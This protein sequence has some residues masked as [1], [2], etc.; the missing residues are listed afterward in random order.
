MSK[1]I[2]RQ[3]FLK[4]LTISATASAL[5]AVGLFHDSFARAIGKVV[6]N[7]N[8]LPIVQSNQASISTP[9]ATRTNTPTPTGTPIP[10]GTPTPTGTLTPTDTPSPTKTT[11]PG[12]GPKV[13]HVH[14]ATAT[15]WDYI[16]G[17]YGDYVDQA[18]VNQ[19]IDEGLK[20]LTGK[21]DIIEAWNYLLPGYEAGKAIAIKVNFNNS[22]QCG[23]T[24]NLVDALMEPV[25]ALIRGMS[26]KGV[27]ASDIWIF[28]AIRDLPSRFL[29]KCL[30]PGVR[31]FDRECSLPATFDSSD[32]NAEVIFQNPSLSNRRVSDVIIDASY[33]INMPI[34]K[35]H[36][37]AGVTLGF[38]N[39]FGTIQQIDRGGED[40][41]HLF[42]DPDDLNYYHPSYNPL[43]D[44][45]SNLHILNKT[46]LVIG[47]GLFGAYG[48]CSNS[49]PPAPWISFENKAP[50]S[51]FLSVDPVA[52]D[53]VMKDILD[54]E[55][56][57]HPKRNGADDYLKLAAGMNMGVYEKGDPWGAGY[58]N[59]NYTKI[60]LP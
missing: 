52:V 37:I 57:D 43:V 19:M 55:P 38:K 31:F 33:L 59:I 25:N 30:Y 44:I 24:D 40:N 21:P 29:T 7:Q 2:N 58:Q 53:C 14:N 28:D 4:L 39:H 15:N 20:A 3:Q 42:I 1:K 49:V 51:F 6:D 56:G 45:Y 50:N 9:T 27:Q 12:V 11:T 17:W 32:P 13:V 35:D 26:E 10:T 48:C 46:I 23:D 16:N 41:L 47:D 18:K 54:A 5:T 60:E 36:G 8:Y 34:I 22:W